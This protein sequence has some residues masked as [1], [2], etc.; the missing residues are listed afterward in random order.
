MKHIFAIYRRDIWSLLIV[1]TGAIVA[2]LFA[3]ACGIV[4]VAQVLHPSSIA[5]MQPVFN[6]AAWLLLLLCPAITMRL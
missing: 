5:T 6:F 4:F 1:P 3:L 2:G